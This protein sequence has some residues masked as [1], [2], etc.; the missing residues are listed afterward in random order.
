MSNKVAAQPSRRSNDASEVGE[1]CIRTSR[2]RRRAPGRHATLGF[3]W[4]ILSI[5]VPL[6]LLSNGPSDRSFA[7]LAVL[8]VIVALA[9][10]SGLVGSVWAGRPRIMAFFFWLFVYLWFGIAPSGQLWFQDSELA[11]TGTVNDRTTA[12]LAVLIGVLCFA[13]GYWL[14][15]RARAIN[16]EANARWAPSL[17]W[18]KLRAFSA[19]ATAAA[20]FVIPKYGG[21][22]SLFSSRQQFAQTSE[23][24]QS[25]SADHSVQ[26][27]LYALL[28]V[29]AL[30]SLLSWFYLHRQG[31]ARQT[32]RHTFL[33]VYLLALNIVSNSPFS[34]PRSWVAVCVLSFVVSS[35][36]LMQ[37]R[38]IAYAA[39]AIVVGFVVLFPLATYFRY[40]THATSET[41]G[42]LS[43]RFIQSGDYD[44]YKQSVVGATYVR[45]NGFDHGRQLLGPLG[46][47][48]PRAVW[49]SK[50]GDTGVLLGKF[51]GAAYTNLSAPLTTELYLAFGLPLVGIGFLALGAAWGQLDR[52]YIA[53]YKR[54]AGLSYMVVPL[55][56]VYQLAVLR[57]SLLTV[58]G[59][60]V[61]ILLVPAVLFL[62]YRRCKQ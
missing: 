24:L 27:I 55:L 44:A 59:F 28:S 39:A 20:V 57:G 29:P 35:R 31:G 26:A 7:F 17:T 18:G 34:H 14:T 9:G 38:R 6:N 1:T 10:A 11:G 19:L 21:V 62:P 12:S 49:Q 25:S 46:F 58:T 16:F 13:I 61:L 54:R 53:A 3:L 43:H 5:A 32:G 56:A 4:T 42:L 45:E 8:H 40:E 52:C 36:R 60:L 41:Q 2:P 15:G 47:W 22:S 50:P 23:L 30:V 48:V 37:P 51:Q 33:L